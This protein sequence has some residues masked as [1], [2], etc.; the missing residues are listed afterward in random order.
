MSVKILTAKEVTAK[1]NGFKKRQDN[2]VKDIQQVA[3]SCLHLVEKDG[4]LTNLQRLYNEM[5][6]VASKAKLAIWAKMNGKLDFDDKARK[7]IYRHK[8]SSDLARAEAVPFTDI[9]L[10]KDESF[11]L[12]QTLVSQAK[13]IMAKQGDKMSTEDKAAFDQ[14][15]SNLNALVTDHGRAKQDVKPVA[16]E[17]PK[18]CEV[19]TNDELVKARAKA[20]AAKT[21]AAKAPKQADKTPATPK[22]AQA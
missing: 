7:F 19:I 20:K 8:K 9:K 4:N 17:S 3:L 1:L 21:R 6:R 22:A 18:L 11:D 10:P 14:H 2:F 12:L 13:A 5:P 15:V 16:D